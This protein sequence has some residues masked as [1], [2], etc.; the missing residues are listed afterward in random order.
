MEK[1]VIMVIED[2]TIVSRGIQLALGNLGY[3][4]SPAARTGEQAVSRA[5]AEKPD[6][7]LMDIS[8]KGEMDGIEAARQIRAASAIPIIFLTAFSDDEKIE[9]SKLSEPSGYII[10]VRLFSITHKSHK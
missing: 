5:L 3:E 9:R 8:L 4:T 1:P 6:M 7:V 10:R 2:E